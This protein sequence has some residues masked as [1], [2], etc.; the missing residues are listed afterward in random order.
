MLSASCSLDSEDD[1]NHFE[2]PDGQDE[3]HSDAGLGN[4]SD[5][6][7]D[8]MYEPEMVKSESNEGHQTNCQTQVATG[9]RPMDSSTLNEM[10]I[11]MLGK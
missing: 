6:A 2:C 9:H 8:S 5:D 1:G 4:M 3:Y 7:F 10:V 11:S